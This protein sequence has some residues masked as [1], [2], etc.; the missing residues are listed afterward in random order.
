MPIPYWAQ[1]ASCQCHTEFSVLHTELSVLHVDITLSSVYFMLIPCW[2]QCTSCLYH[3][4]FRILHANTIP[5]SVYFILIPYTV[6]C[7]SYCTSIIL[8][9]MYFI[10]IPC[11]VQ[12]TSYQY[13]THFCVLDSYRSVYVIPTSYALQ[14][15]CL[16][17][18]ID[19]CWCLLLLLICVQALTVTPFLLFFTARSLF[20]T[21]WHPVGCASWML[22]LTGWRA[23]KRPTCAPSP[24]SFLWNHPV[25]KLWWDSKT[26]SDAY[27]Y[28][29]WN[30]EQKTAK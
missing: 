22:R 2:V 25:L 13:H 12:C 1:C 24:D 29:W 14:C 23:S 8:R 30:T 21:S 17:V 19:F 9:S 3:T 16:S 28:I 26:L 7:T 10:L 20:K 11:S 27:I 15:T 5:V 18:C 6:Q 4:K